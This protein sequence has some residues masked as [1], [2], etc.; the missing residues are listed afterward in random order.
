VLASQGDPRE[1]ITDPRSSYFGIVVGERALVP[2][3]DAA[4]GKIRF[5]DW[6]G[7]LAAAPNGAA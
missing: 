1:V 3:P 4:V 7:Q 2:G 5:D 6:F